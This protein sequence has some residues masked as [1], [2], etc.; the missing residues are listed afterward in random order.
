MSDAKRLTEVIAPSGTLSFTTSSATSYDP[1]SRP[2][3]NT[4][5][6]A[7]SGQVRL[8]GHVLTEM[9]PGV[10]RVPG[11]LTYSDRHLG[12]EYDTK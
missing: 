11:E 3:D 10:R 12:P 4:D 7:S 6:D 8:K 9:C 1:A 5:C 2:G